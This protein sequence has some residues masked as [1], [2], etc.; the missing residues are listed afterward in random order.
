MASEDG[1]SLPSPGGGERDSIATHGLACQ[2]LFTKCVEASESLKEFL[3]LEAHS[4]RY[5]LWAKNIAAHHDAILPSS[6]EYR[7]RD[8]EHACKIV[9]KALNYLS[10][11]L[12]LILSILTGEKENE[13]WDSTSELEELDLAV[14]EGITNLFE[15]SM[16][17][18]KKPEKDEYIK[19]SQATSFDPTPD[20]VH[21]GDKYPLTRDSNVWLKERLG[22]AI[23]RR[24]QYLRYRKDH[25]EKME[26]IHEMK[27]NA[28][29]KTMWSGEKASTYLQ[30]S[31][32]AKAPL[33]APHPPGMS[34][35]GAGKRPQTEYADSSRGKDG[36]TDI[37]RTPRLPK[38]SGGVRVEYGQ[39]F[40]CPYCR[41]PQNVRDKNEWK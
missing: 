38:D 41:R 5:D 29:G 22:T 18:R 16:I 11:S 12:E 23:T 34:S 19:A 25:Q 14:Q 30:E 15:L 2:T 9:K 13:K 24:R 32:F 20:I 31:I 10:E 39:H 40:E 6:L 7:I 37:L 4:R 33:N 21:V 3:N 1:S 35:I 27:K 36:A 26:Q 28:D 8:D 17:I